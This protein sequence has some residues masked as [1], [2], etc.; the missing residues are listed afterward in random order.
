RRGSRPLKGWLRRIGAEVLAAVFFLGLAVLSTRPL[1]AHLETHLVG[2]GDPVVD[3]WTIDW[4][5]KHFFESRLIFQGNIF[6]PAPHAV[7]YSD[8]SIAPAALLLPFRRWLTHPVPLYNVAVLLPLAFA[9]RPFRA[10]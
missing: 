4:L 5:A 3:L 7:L 9:G 1:A 6:H 8:L 2:A 10:P